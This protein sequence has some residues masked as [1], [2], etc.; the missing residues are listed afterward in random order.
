MLPVLLDAVCTPA[1]YWSRDIRASVPGLVLEISIWSNP[2]F[3]FFFR[4]MGGDVVKKKMILLL[5]TIE[6]KFREVERDGVV[7]AF[8]VFLNNN[9]QSKVSPFCEWRFIIEQTREMFAWNKKKKKN[10]T[11][12]HNL[13]FLLEIKRKKKKQVVVRDRKET[14][15]LC[16]GASLIRP[17]PHPSSFFSLGLFPSSNT[18]VVYLPPPLPFAMS[19]SLSLSLSSSF[20]SIRPP[21]NTHQHIDPLQQYI[22]GASRWPVLKKT[23][24]RKRPPP[25]PIKKK[26]DFASSF[27]LFPI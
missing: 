23:T 21:V 19:L 25:P 11:R 26:I 4:G 16:G 14:K 15:F 7:G 17:V 6:I 10:T 20:L 13:L 22:L 2:I 12:T 24:I 5:Q 27:F 9:S 1:A 18:R 8:I 3:V